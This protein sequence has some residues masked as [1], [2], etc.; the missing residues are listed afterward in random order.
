MPTRPTVYLYDGATEYEITAE[1][2]SV[3]LRRGRNLETD[4]IDAGGGTIQCRNLSRNFDPFFASVESDLLLETGDRLLQESTDHILLDGSVGSIGSYGVITQGRK[5]VVKDGAVTVYT[6]FVE[7]YDYEWDVNGNATATLV[8]RDSLATLARTEFLEWTTTYNEPTGTRIGTVLDRAEVGF[9]SGASAR[10]LDTGLIRCQDDYVSYGSNVLNYLQLVART[11]FGRLFVNRTGVLTFLDRYAVFNAT[12]TVSFN[13]TGTGIP[14]NAVRVRYGSE[15]LYFKVS[16]Q[17]FGGVTQTATNAAA[18]AANENLGVRHLTISNLLYRSD[19]YSL[20]L[21]TYLADRYSSAEAVV[22]SLE[23]PLGK[24]STADRA[25]VTALDIGSVIDL[26]W[27]P[28]RSGGVV[29]QTL[30]V[31]GVSYSASYTGECVL[32]LQLSD[33][34][35]AAYLIY[36]TDAYDSGKLYG[37]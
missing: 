25:T 8:V 29:T 16:V 20:A 26:T 15:L 31:E 37:F 14:F 3:S 23:I 19:A 32:S 28:T 6:G 18:I 1:A 17:R 33:A 13:D 4:E 27:T 21:A 24:L 7:D 30:A 5:V 9:P 34:R 22:S 35:S 11:E 10:D 2:F 12:A 36:D